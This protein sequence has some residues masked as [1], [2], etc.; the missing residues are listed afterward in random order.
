MSTNFYLDKNSGKSGF[1]DRISG[2]Q[3]AETCRNKL[4][5]IK[6]F[7]Q[8]TIINTI[9]IKDLERWWSIVWRLLNRWTLFD[10]NVLV[11]GSNATDTIF[12]WSRGL[13]A[14]QRSYNLSD[15]PRLKRLS[16]LNTERVGTKRVSYSSWVEKENRR[17]RK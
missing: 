4:P 7:D 14:V 15:Q 9:A 17:E 11:D 10:T 3:T 8:I 1:Q 12:S 5:A 16:S 13:H 2:P 6:H